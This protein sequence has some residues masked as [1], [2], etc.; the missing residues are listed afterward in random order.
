MGQ[1]HG[2]PSSDDPRLPGPPESP[3]EPPDVVAQPL[4]PP[5]RAIERSKLAEDYATYSPARRRPAEPVPAPLNHRH[6][7]SRSS[8][9]P[10]RP[11]R[12]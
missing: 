2:F 10:R 6:A 11:S 9:R 12:S 1:P 8:H 4:M 7:L 3:S 5:S